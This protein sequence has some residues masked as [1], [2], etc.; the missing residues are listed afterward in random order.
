MHRVLEALQRHTDA[1]PLPLIANTDEG[2]AFGAR[3]IN[4]TEQLTAALLTRYPALTNSSVEK[5]L[6]LYPD[7]AS[8]GAP[9]NTGD[10]YLSTGLQD[11]VSLFKCLG[12]GG[13]GTDDAFLAAR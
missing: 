1:P 11:K 4:T 5:L 10:G 8:L 9:Y 7:D 3:G 12:A 2:T 6:E 13:S